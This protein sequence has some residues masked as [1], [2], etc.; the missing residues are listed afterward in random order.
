MWN[1]SAEQVQQG[2]YNLEG[3]QNVLSLNDFWIFPMMTYKHSGKIKMN[4]YA[5]NRHKLVEPG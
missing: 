3:K 4:L 5:T 1:K 2:K